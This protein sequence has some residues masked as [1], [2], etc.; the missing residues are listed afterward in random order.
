MTEDN[1]KIAPMHRVTVALSVE[2]AGG[3]GRETP[4]ATFYTFILGVASGGMSPFEYALLDRAPG[5]VVALN[6]SPEN[7]HQ[8]FEHLDSALDF[9]GPSFPPLRLRV[10]VTAVAPAAPREIVQAMASASGCGCGCG[11]GCG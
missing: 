8:V 7:R 6:I 10:E 4:A 3:D 1:P 9:L 5:E 2:T 11:C